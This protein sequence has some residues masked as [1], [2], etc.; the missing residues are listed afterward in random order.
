[1]RLYEKAIRSAQ[2]NSF[3]HNEALAYVGKWLEEAKASG[4]VRRVFD[5]WGFANADVAPAGR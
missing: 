4:A 1:M 2:A 5:R 3:V